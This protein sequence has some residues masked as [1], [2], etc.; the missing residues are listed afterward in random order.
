MFEV[1]RGVFDDARDVYGV[2][3]TDNVG[4]K[5]QRR[6]DEGPGCANLD[7]SNDGGV[8]MG[9]KVGTLSRMPS[10]KLR[11]SFLF[12]HRSEDLVHLGDVS[13]RQFLEL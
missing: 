4:V 13:V 6:Y 10:G 12:L 5:S 2:K 8:T 9:N 11:G 7:L 1:S 3:I